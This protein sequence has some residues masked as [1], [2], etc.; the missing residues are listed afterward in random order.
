[1]SD[2]ALWKRLESVLAQRIEN[3]PG[4]AGLCLCDLA[5]ER[6][7]ALNGDEL[8]PTASTIKAPV[9][10]R[11]L[12]LAEQGVLDL[13]ATTAVPQ[14]AIVGGSG[15]LGH[16]EGY[17]E[18]GLLLSRLDVA[19]LMIIVSDNTATDLCIDWCGLDSV[20]QMLDALGLPQT[21]LN[22]KLMDL[23]A[24]RR[25][26]ENVSTPAELVR[27][28]TLLYQGHPTSYVSQRALAILRKPKDGMLEKA[29]PL[30]NP[31]LLANKPG[32]IGRVRCDAGVVY[33][34][35]RP[36]AVAIMS[37]FGLCTPAE[38]EQWVVETAHAIYGTMAA[39]DTSNIYGNG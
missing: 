31:P 4:V 30:L 22:R 29:L 23:E 26:E 1:M 35:N 7:I 39:L 12:E 34:L 2:L 20:N 8:F 33:L 11:V 14:S 3:F 36:Y 9:L 24:A 10:M 25:N 19:I 18:H 38:Q 15:V 37:K 32:A 5:T 13:N 21:R 28:F 17:G 6:Q 16:L 27:L